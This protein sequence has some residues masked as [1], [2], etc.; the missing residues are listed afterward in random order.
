DHQYIALL[1]EQD[2]AQRGKVM[3]LGAAGVLVGFTIAGPTGPWVYTHYGVNGMCLGSALATAI[4]F[5][6]CWNWV[7]E[8]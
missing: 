6:I 1:S 7:R 5:L 3:T 2:P 8:N 4:A